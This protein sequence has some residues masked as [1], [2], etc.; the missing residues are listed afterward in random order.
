M[1][2]YQKLSEKKSLETNHSLLYYTAMGNFNSDLVCLNILKKFKKMFQKE[3]LVVFSFCLWMVPI[4]IF[5]LNRHNNI[6]NHL[7]YLWLSILILVNKSTHMY[8]ILFP[9]KIAPMPKI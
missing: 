9:L 2:N 8:L 5:L 7:K 4:E 3:V 6:K 1:K